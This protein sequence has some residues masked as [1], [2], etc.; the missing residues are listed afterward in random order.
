MENDQYKTKDLSEAS[1][2]VCAG[3]KLIRLESASNFF[4]F[5]FLDKRRCEELSASYWS[6]ELQ[7][8]AKSYADS[9]RSLKDRLFARQ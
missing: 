1:A 9:I 4:Y 7:V 6:G 5:V 8:S 3:A 2:L